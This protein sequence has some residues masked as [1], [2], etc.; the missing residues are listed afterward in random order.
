[1]ISMPGLSQGVSSPPLAIGGVGGS[2]T[3]LIARLLLE[4]GWYLGEDLNAEHDNLWFTLLFKRVEILESTDE[5]ILGLARLFV[6]CMSGRGCRSS[7]NAAMIRSLAM[8][9]RSQ[10][11]AVW[12]QAREARLLVASGA[13]PGQPWGWKEPNTHLVIDRLGQVIPDLRYIHVVRNGLDMAYSGNQNQLDFWGPRVLGDA[14]PPSPGRSLHYWCWV[15][16]RVQRLGQAMGR[17]FLWLNYDRFC[18]SP[19]EGMRLL[20][21]FLGLSVSEAATMALTKLV[22]PPASIGRFK[23]Q[24]LGEFAAGD[25]AYVRQL[26]FDTAID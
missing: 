15:H 9:D 14:M 24:G 26:G 19:A 18:A 21:D 17:N 5:E 8:A 16:R 1:M 20:L 25:L 11:P 12:L 13:A 10:H 23:A 7:K 2:G 4:L 6:D 22:V 3:R